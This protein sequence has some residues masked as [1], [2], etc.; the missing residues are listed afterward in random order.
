MKEHP[1]IPRQQSLEFKLRQ[2]NHGSVFSN[3]CHTSLIYIFILLPIFFRFFQNI[4]TQI[5]PLINCIS[6][7]GFILRKI[8]ANLY[9]IHAF[10]YTL[11]F[12]FFFGVFTILILIFITDRNGVQLAYCWLSI[13][14]GMFFFCLFN[15]NSI[16]KMFMDWSKILK[17]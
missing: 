8:G 11:L 6:I 13:F 14:T 10:L 3:C 5:G 9:L 15:T 16:S 12:T 7:V 1:E 2:I 17:K 4:F